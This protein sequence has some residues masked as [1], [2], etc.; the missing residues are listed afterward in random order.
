MRAVDSL[1]FL[2]SCKGD[3]GHRSMR[4]CLRSGVFEAERYEDFVALAFEVVFGDGSRRSKLVELVEPGHDLG[5][6]GRSGGFLVSA[7]LASLSLGR[8]SVVA[9]GGYPSLASTFTSPAHF[10]LPVMCC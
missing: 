4:C 2:F 9:L 1:V 3:S 5:L 6:V 7:L 10:D 8:F